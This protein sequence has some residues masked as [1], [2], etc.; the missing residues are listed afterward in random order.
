MMQEIIHLM[1]NTTT[2][3]NVRCQLDRRFKSPPNGKMRITRSSII[4]SKPA[5]LHP[6]TTTSQVR[7]GQVLESF[8]QTSAQARHKPGTGDFR[9]GTRCRRNGWR[10]EAASSG[11]DVTSQKDGNHGTLVG[12]GTNQPIS[13]P[14][15]I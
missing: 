11:L 2:K 1:Y 6:P 10:A 3:T 4:G 13:R 15:N 9:A 7:S 5:D 8:Q 12:S 14:I